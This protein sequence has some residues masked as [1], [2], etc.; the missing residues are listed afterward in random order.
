M[1]GVAV[2][3]YDAVKICANW[4]TQVNVVL[5]KASQPASQPGCAVQPRLPILP[6]R[7][8]RPPPSPTAP[9]PT[10]TRL[11][12]TTMLLPDLSADSVLG[13]RELHCC[14]GTAAHAFGGQV[15]LG[16]DCCVQPGERRR[17]RWQQQDRLNVE[18]NTVSTAGRKLLG[19]DTCC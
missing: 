17:Q 5:P 3:M 2:T 8:S 14:C 19:Q 12:P 10:P 7:P 6:M 13:E 1:K 9:A 4:A 11:T 16:D 15:N 18:C